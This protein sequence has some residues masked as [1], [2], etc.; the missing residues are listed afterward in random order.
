MPVLTRPD[1]RPLVHLCED[2]FKKGLL[3]KRITPMP[4]L[5]RP[6]TRPLVHLSEDYFNKAVTHASVN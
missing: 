1:T 5:T 4:V 6:A 2:Y 3:Q